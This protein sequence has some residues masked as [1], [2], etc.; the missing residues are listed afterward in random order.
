MQTAELT[1]LPLVLMYH[2][3][4]RCE[5]DPFRITVSPRRF[6][7]QMRWLAR[8][9]AAGCSMSELLDGGSDDR[10][11]A[12]V[13]LT[14]DDGY[15]DFVTGA[16]PVL[17]EFGFTATVFVVAGRLGGDNGWDRQGPRKALMSAEHVRA[18]ADAGMEIGSHGLRHVR[19]TSVPEAQLHAEV[20]LSRELLEDVTGRPVTGFCYPYG[21]VSEREADA[22]SRA[23]YRYGC[24]V[25]SSPSPGRYALPRTYVGDRDGALRLLA[26]WARHRV[27]AGTW[28]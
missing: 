26:K 13:G 20:G 14:F 9:G 18:V 8:L 5:D 11:G 27:R 21:A 15:R 25:L 1:S 6:A 3:V 22:V 19:L 4:V 17:R 24:A 23:G 28:V 16:L 2:S 10:A 12:R 7:E